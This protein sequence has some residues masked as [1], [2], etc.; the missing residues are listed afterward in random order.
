MRFGLDDSVAAGE[1][2]RQVKWMIED[3]LPLHAIWLRDAPTAEGTWKCR[4]QVHPQCPWKTTL[5][6]PKRSRER[7]MEV[8]NSQCLDRKV[9]RG[10]WGSEWDYKLY[11]KQ[12]RME[13]PK[14][15]RIYTAPTPTATLWRASYY[16]PP[17]LG[18]YIDSNPQE[19]QGGVRNLKPGFFTGKIY[20]LLVLKGPLLDFIHCFQCL[21]TQVLGKYIILL[22]LF[23]FV[24][25]LSDS[26]YGMNMTVPNSLF[27]A[28]IVDRRIPRVRSQREKHMFFWFLFGNFRWKNKHG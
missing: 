11:L 8:W 25:L 1:P 2:P 10:Q 6:A 20:S 14:N 23:S 9:K 7:M 26:T 21:G 16:K 15:S 24:F 4:E 27:W 5:E 3:Y 22:D 12:E 17:H 28:K 18:K 13:C 19:T